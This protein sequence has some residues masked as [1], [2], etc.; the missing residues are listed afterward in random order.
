M[1][2]FFPQEGYLR[3]SFS[4]HCATQHV[5]SQTRD[6]PLSHRR[7]RASCLLFH[8]DL[9]V[10]V[11]LNDKKNLLCVNEF[12]SLCIFHG[13]IVLQMSKLDSVQQVWSVKRSCQAAGKHYSTCGETRRRCLS[14]SANDN[15]A[16]AESS[17]HVCNPKIL[18]FQQFWTCSVSLLPWSERR[19]TRIKKDTDR[20][21]LAFF[22]TLTW[23]NN[24][25]FYQVSCEEEERIFTLWGTCIFKFETNIFVFLKARK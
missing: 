1:C 17:V 23:V 11:K 13:F 8:P 22:F 3:A 21:F 16:H 4:N 9:W 5:F 14:D 2:H 15:T 19:L 20:D 18:I 24:Y 7:K 12:F 6:Q 10:V 25:I